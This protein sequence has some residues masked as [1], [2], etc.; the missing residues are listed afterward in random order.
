MD[1]K[2]KRL[3]VEACVPT[4]GSE[5]AAAY[6]IYAC[7]TEE[8]RQVT[9]PPHNTVIVGTGLCMAPPEGYFIGIYARSGLSTREGLRLANCVGVCD[10]DYRGEY[11]VALHND[12]DEPRIIRH[13]DRIA[14][15]IL[16]E[17]FD[18]EFSIVDEL[19]DTKRGEGGF[20]S[21]GN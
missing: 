1:V 10:E 18:M 15:I 19:D 12:S 5:K 16:Q 20:G 2:I 11:K 7:L 6:D 13:G 9:I 21:T 3:N 4:R 8:K 14:Q 17:R